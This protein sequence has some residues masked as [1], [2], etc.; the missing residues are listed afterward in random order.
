MQVSCDLNLIDLFCF[1]R[2]HI[3]HISI[4]YSENQESHKLEQNH[5]EFQLHPWSTGKS[6]GCGR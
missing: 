4:Y 3:I 2:T 6:G 1:L 5:L